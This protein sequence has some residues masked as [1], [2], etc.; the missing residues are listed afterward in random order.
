[1][2]KLICDFIELG[3]ICFNLILNGYFSYFF[4]TSK[5][6]FTCIF[7]NKCVFFFF[8]HKITFL[9]HVWVPQFTTTVRDIGGAMGHWI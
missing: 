7:I 5:E 2:K 8:L 6:T 4:C 3:C 1:M 9:L